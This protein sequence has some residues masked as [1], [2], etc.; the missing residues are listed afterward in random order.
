MTNLTELKE[1]IEKGLDKLS[2]TENLDWNNSENKNVILDYNFLQGKLK[3]INETLSAVREDVKW[4]RDWLDVGTSKEAQ[5]NQLK[6][7]VKLNDICE[8]LELQIPQFKL[9]ESQ[10]PKIT[11]NGIPSKN[12]GDVSGSA[13]TP[14]ASYRLSCKGAA[15]KKGEKGK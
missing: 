15:G 3:G 9:D 12:L 8:M 1:K 2:Y 6:V 4:C 5:E 11:E 7:L 13:E 14:A 10:A